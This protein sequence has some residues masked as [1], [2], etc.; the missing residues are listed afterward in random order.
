[1]EH[2]EL[3]ET[4]VNFMKYL[5]SGVEGFFFGALHPNVEDEPV[6]YEKLFN[7]LREASELVELGF[8]EDVSADFK[9][10]IDKSITEHGRAYSVL[11]ITPQGISMFGEGN[12][13]VN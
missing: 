12:E 5:A 2:F 13:L 3:S 1:M 10:Q 6:T 9:E 4:Q 7:S 11:V 8:L